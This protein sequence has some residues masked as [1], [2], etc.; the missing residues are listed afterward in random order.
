[1]R[2][3]SDFQSFEFT[4]A[5]T[6]AK[7]ERRSRTRYVIEGSA[8]FKW[9]EEGS[10]ALRGE[11][12]TRDLSVSGAFIQSHTIPPLGADAEVTISL[13]STTHEYLQARLSGSGRVCRVEVCDGDAGGF[14]VAVNLHA[15]GPESG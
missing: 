9:V 4:R 8:S 11:G 2:N 10:Q 12:V 15:G 1:M 13:L 7:C 6:G 5:R 14:G 3:E